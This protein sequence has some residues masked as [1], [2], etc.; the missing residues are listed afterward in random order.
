MTIVLP[1]YSGDAWLL[2]KNLRWMQE[3]DTKLDYDCILSFDNETDPTNVKAIARDL[4]RSI[5][6]IRYDRIAESQWPRPQNNA[7]TSTAWQMEKLG[8]PW[9]WFETDAVPIK[10]GWLDRINES[11]LKNKKPFT[12]HWNEES[13]V[14][15][16]TAVYPPNVARYSVRAMTATLTNGKDGRQ[17]PWDVYGSGEIEP[18]L[19]KANDIFQHK[20]EHDGASPTFPDI[21]SVS[22]I[23]R[24]GISVFHRCKDGTLI[25]RIRQRTF[26]SKSPKAEPPCFVQL[27]R[28][29]DLIMLLPA[30]KFYADKFGAPVPVFVGKDFAS[31]LDGASYVK[32]I[33]V[34]CE[35]EEAATI[36]R[37]S[38]PQVIVTQLNGKKTHPQ[39]DS[40]KSYA[41]TMW[42]R[43]GLLGEYSKMLPVFDQRRKREEEKLVK[44]HVK[45]DRPIVLVNFA[46]NTS[47]FQSPELLSELRKRTDIQLIDLKEVRASR[48]FDLLGLFDIAAGMIT[49]DTMTLHLAAASQMPYVALLADHGKSAS[50][51]KG[52]CRM[53][54]GYSKVRENVGKIMMEVGSWIRGNRFPSKSRYL[55]GTGFHSKPGQNRGDFFA[56]WH[57]NTM[58]YAKPERVIVMASGGN[59]IQGAPG[60][61]IHLDGDIGHTHDL[62]NGRKPYHWCGWSIA[63]VNL[64]LLAYANECDFIFKE[65]DVLA[66]GPW[67]DRMY[68]EIGEAG[69]IFGKAKCMPAV[70]SLLLCKHWFIPRFVELYMGTGSEQL[71]ENE[72]ELKFMRLE[73]QHPKLFARYSFG[74]DR[75]R[76]I[77]YDDDVFYAQHLQPAEMDELRL[78]KLI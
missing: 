71:K 78:R 77:N 49:I 56:T 6:E 69:M 18:Y 19:N 53:S 36:A 55:I 52:N 72:G 33:V 8:Q 5:R 2:E 47:P 23:L 20:W 40:L 13:N 46:G 43:T 54:V 74:Y 29:G 41:E 75:D 50:V 32:P 14:F 34:S 11:H 42:H 16:G 76:P 45:D 37:K 27:G 4:F 59:K 66:F 58:K 35:L 61:W 3:L 10:P 70:Q 57:A 26:A 62:S 28:Y 17:P 15:N 25:D 51:P 60:Q 39:P 64:A 30:F 65:Q 38:Y 12:G 73:Q 63:L 44:A 7:F 68:S 1:F 48:V 22:E 24:N 67:V 21:K 9:L 31:V